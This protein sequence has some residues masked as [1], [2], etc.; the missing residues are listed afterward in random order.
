MFST[1]NLFQTLD[2]LETLFQN[3]QSPERSIMYAKYALLELCGWIEQAEDH[4]VLDAVNSLT[5]TDLKKHITE[6]VSKNYSFEFK[7]F[8]SLLCSVIGAIEYEKMCNE[9]LPV[10]TGTRPFNSLESN[11]DLLKRT[12]NQHAH[13]HFEPGNQRNNFAQVNS[14]PNLSPNLLKQRAKDIYEGFEELERSLKTT[15]LRL[16]PPP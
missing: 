11:I 16:R 6:S 10:T 4:I 13:T 2:E 3:A 14:S 15:L 7:K 12:R 5:D 9:N 1:G 8:V